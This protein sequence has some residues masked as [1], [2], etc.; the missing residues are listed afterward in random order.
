MGTTLNDIINTIREKHDIWVNIEVITDIYSP[1]SSD[2]TIHIHDIGLQLL[3]DSITQR[4]RCITIHSFN[5]SSI[6]FIYKQF[7]FLPTIAAC[8]PSIYNIRT[9]TIS[10]DTVFYHEKNNTPLSD[11]SQ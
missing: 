7:L 10:G 6:P 11:N 8:P 1:Y 9:D 2:I 5:Y 4:L 3:V